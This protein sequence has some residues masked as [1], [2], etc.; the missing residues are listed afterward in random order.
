MKIL[1]CF[2]ILL[3]TLSQASPSE[4]FY[5]RKKDVLEKRKTNLITKVA[6]KLKI[7]ER[8]AYKDI[9]FKLQ[10]D[11]I[12]V[13]GFIEGYLGLCKVS[14]NLSLENSQTKFICISSNSNVTY[15]FL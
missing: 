12:V 4:V 7:S 14:G 1:I 6:K 10:N 2:L 9:Q 8:A 5:Q 13:S 3:P 11:L 15:F